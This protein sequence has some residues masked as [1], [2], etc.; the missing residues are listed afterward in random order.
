VAGP[1]SLAAGIRNLTAQYDAGM[2]ESEQDQD[3]EETEPEDEEPELLPDREEMSVIDL[4]GGLGP[5]AP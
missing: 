2:S 4:E 1:A 5:P 3:V